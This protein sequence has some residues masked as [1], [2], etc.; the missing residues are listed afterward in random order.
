MSLESRIT[1]LVQ[2]IASDIKF[3]ISKILHRQNISVSNLP[4]GALVTHALDSTK[5]HVT[6]YDPSGRPLRPDAIDYQIID[7]STI[8]IYLPI[9]DEGTASFSGD[10]FLIDRKQ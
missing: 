4:D 2:A 3:L 6:F 7:A 10:I 9:P 1:A 8:K 5:L